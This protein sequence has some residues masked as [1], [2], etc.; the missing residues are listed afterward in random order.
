MKAQIDDLED[1]F[2]DLYDEELFKKGWYWVVTD[3][4]E[5]VVG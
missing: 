3:K 5:V 2:P 1:D 4:N